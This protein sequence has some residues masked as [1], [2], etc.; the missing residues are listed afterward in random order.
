M[1]GPKTLNFRGETYKDEP[2]Q[3]IFIIRNRTAFGL[4][5]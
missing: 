4:P 5:D 1:E 3:I 2:D